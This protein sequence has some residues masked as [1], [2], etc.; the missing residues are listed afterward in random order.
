M[1]TATLSP[2]RHTGNATITNVAMTAL[3]W[4]V[5][6]AYSLLIL[7]DS[8]QLSWLQWIERNI[9]WMIPAIAILDLIPIGVA[10]VMGENEYKID[11]LMP[12][13]TFI[14]FVIFTS[15]VIS[16]GL[17]H[18]STVTFFVA[19]WLL[20]VIDVMIAYYL[21]PILRRGVARLRWFEGRVAELEGHAWPAGTTVPPRASEP[22]DL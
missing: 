13:F 20:W 22:Y 16:R 1:T 17:M 14:V 8:S 2:G 4:T 19:C 3:F 11:R 15:M 9:A 10:F 18:G 7:N 5:M 6:G 21:M 12:I